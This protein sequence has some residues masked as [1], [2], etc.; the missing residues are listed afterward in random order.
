MRS[1]GA[2]GIAAAPPCS[3]AVRLPGRTPFDGMKE[4]LTLK[5]AK[6]PAFG[7]GSEDT[8]CNQVTTRGAQFY[9]GPRACIGARFYLGRAPAH[10]QAPAL[11][12]MPSCGIEASTIRKEHVHGGS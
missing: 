4:V 5:L 8:S 10:G 11:G 6:T 1:G 9:A 7:D 12:K 2:A 3:I